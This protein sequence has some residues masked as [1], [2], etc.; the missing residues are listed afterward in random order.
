MT[1]AERTME[2]LSVWLNAHPMN[3]CFLDADTKSDK[4]KFLC[5]LRSEPKESPTEYSVWAKTLT[6]AIDSALEKVTATKE[7]SE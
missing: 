6:E 5:V 4:E 7:E 1:N 2:R 3:E